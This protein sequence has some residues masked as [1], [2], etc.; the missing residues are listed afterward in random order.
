MDFREI[1]RVV[2]TAVF[3]DDVLFDKLVLKGGNALNIVHQ[4]GAVT[5]AAGVDLED[6]DFYFDYVLKKVKE[7]ESLWVV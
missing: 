6:Y 4:V 2:I 7:L 3:S 1:R 5:V